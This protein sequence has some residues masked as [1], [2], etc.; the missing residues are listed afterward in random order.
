M[1]RIKIAWFIILFIILFSTA[2]AQETEKNNDEKLINRRVLILDFVNTQGDKNY[3]YL[4]SSIPDAFL[5]PLDKTK[6]F[7]LLKRN[8]WQK[9]IDE[10]IYVK[11]DA[12][13][14]EKAIEAAKKG[15]AD[16][17]VIGSFIAIGSEMLMISKAIEISSERVMVVR[18][19]K[20]GID[21]SMF[22]A[23]LQLANE[24]SK[25]M[26]NKL[27]PL[28]Q[29]VIFQ[30]RIKYMAVDSKEKDEEESLGLFDD[31]K[32]PGITW[33]SLILPGWGHL[34]SDRSRGWIYIGLWTASLGFLTYAITEEINKYNAYDTEKRINTLYEEYD[35]AYKRRWIAT[36]TCIGV[37]TISFF[38]ALFFRSSPPSEKKEGAMLK[39][40]PDST[41]IAF[42]KKF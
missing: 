21:S 18:Q 25:E 22:D 19:K 8:I 40:A 34:Y 42:Y 6:S 12:H 20:T 35:T 27:P 5:A 16:V 7:E 29:R 4:E 2:N 32:V 9:M 28:P 23:I 31:P 39:L 24:M 36:Y 1:K 38:D 26:K 17:V 11:K 37:Y 30:D 41:E 14:E 3:E 33:R 10:G 13:K 15:G